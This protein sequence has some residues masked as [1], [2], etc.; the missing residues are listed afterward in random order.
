MPA[1]DRSGRANPGG[2][3]MKRNVM[4]SSIVLIA[5]ALALIAAAC[6]SS[7]KNSSSG[8]NATT[9]TGAAATTTSCTGA[10]GSGG[11]AL[12]GLMPQSGDLKVIYKSL[13]T[14]TQMAVDEI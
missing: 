12:G 9:T 5:M 4:P 3:P 1:A 11:L 14:P 2:G 6:G 7:S 10:T 8:S 13:C